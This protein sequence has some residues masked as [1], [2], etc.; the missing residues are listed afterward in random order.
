MRIVPSGYLIGS[1]L[2]LIGLGL[3]TGYNW[4][5]RTISDAWYYD[6]VEA[7]VVGTGYACKR[8]PSHPDYV[9]GAQPEPCGALAGMSDTDLRVRKLNMVRRFE[10]TY[11]SPVDGQAHTSHFFSGSPVN[12]D[13]DEKLRIGETGPILAS[14]NEPDEIKAWVKKF[15]G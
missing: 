4:A 10:V 13:F 2:F 15:K 11:I 7:R 14:T 3:V 12:S 1:V 6:E 9:E 8:T 5:S